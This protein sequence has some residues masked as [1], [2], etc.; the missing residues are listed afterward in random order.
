MTPQRSCHGFMF[1]SPSPEKNKVCSS[2][3]NSAP[4]T[5]LDIWTDWCTQ[6]SGSPKGQPD[7]GVPHGQQSPAGGGAV[8][9]ALCCAASSPAHLCH[10]RGPESS[11]A[12]R[13]SRKG[14]LDLTGYWGRAMWK[15]PKLHRTLERILVTAWEITL[16]A[17]RCTKLQPTG[18]K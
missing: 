10:C 14:R 7:P 11:D 18:K 6:C 16:S 12:H 1:Y 3:L 13:S 8:P 17:Y 5:T 4:G 2:L 15:T 9:S